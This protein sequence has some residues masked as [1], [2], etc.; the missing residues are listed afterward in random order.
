MI[1]YRIKTKQEFIDEFGESWRCVPCSFLH[2]M[3]YLLGEEIDQN[4]TI[5]VLEGQTRLD[6]SLVEKCFN[7]K[8]WSIS[9]AML[10]EIKSLPN[11]NEKKT[12]VYD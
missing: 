5:I 3:D 4:T 8:H 9:Y 2:N 7:Y 11:Y 6:L 10:K 1:R 12:L